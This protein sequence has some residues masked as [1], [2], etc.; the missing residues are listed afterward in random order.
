MRDL[1]RNGLNNFHVQSAEIL[2]GPVRRRI[3]GATC[4][5]Q[6]NISC[7]KLGNFTLAFDS[8]QQS[9]TRMCYDSTV[10]PEDPVLCRPQS[11][12][13]E[14]LA[15]LAQEGHHAGQ[16]EIPETHTGIGR[17]N[18]KPIREAANVLLL[19]ICRSKPTVITPSP[20]WLEK[21]RY[22][23]FWGRLR[24]KYFFCNLC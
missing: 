11:V 20:R 24:Y 16:T 7:L 1:L 19:G 18:E 22:N 8:G 3:F 5:G 9:E 21:F 12:D 17:Y 13:S 10:R 6:N 14:T 15:P 4:A 23:F 2:N